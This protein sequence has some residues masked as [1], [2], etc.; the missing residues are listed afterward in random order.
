MLAVVLAA[1]RGTRL[2][3]LT[4]DRSKAMMPIAGRL[5][6]AR[7][8]S[9]LSAGGADS[10]VV[11]V[12]PEQDELIRYLRECSWKTRVELVYQA[13]REGMAD[14]VEAAAPAVIA[15][16]ETEFLL[17]SCDN[18]F[19]NGHVSRLTTRRRRDSLDA[20][21]SLMW[22]S[23]TEATS[24]A[25]VE[26]E[27]GLV[28]DIIEKPNLTDIPSYSSCSSVLTAPSLYALSTPVLA[29]LAHVRY[30]SR[31]ERE[32]P[33]VLRL[34]VSDGGRVGG[35]L[36]DDRMTLTHP[37]DLLVINRRF[38]RRTP[39]RAIVHAEMP[40]DVTITPPVHIEAGVRVG[41]ECSIGP[42]VFLERGC[43]VREGAVVRRAVVL[44]SG[45]IAANQLVDDTLVM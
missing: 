36:V 8:L 3:A 28:T 26:M 12:H 1:G 29:Y 4:T 32:F 5:M 39:D 37:Q 10:F 41:T 21:L 33:D 24:S 38:L 22:A 44:R 20:A 7:V 42:E 9:M 6:I 13:Q 40:R 16:A 2:G 23:R 45:S 18:L 14:A 11:V 25:V 31:G 27:D 35:E 15:R 34:L 19:P 30:S 43:R 17:A